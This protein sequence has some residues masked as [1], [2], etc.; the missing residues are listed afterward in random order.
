MNDT[1]TITV[2]VIGRYGAWTA[3]TPDGRTHRGSTRREAMAAAISSEEARLA[4]VM[5]RAEAL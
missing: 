5:H 2:V 1:R 4:R 3:R